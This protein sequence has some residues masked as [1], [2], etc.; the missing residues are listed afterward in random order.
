[1][2]TDVW[3]ERVESKA[4]FQLNSLK[5][6]KLNFKLQ[7]IFLGLSWCTGTRGNSFCFHNHTWSYDAV[8]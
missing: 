4:P 5:D 3:I 2:H 8:R 6:F 7:E 1:M